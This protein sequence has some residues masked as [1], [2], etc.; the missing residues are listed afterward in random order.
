VTAAFVDLAVTEIKVQELGQGALIQ[1]TVKNLGTATADANLYKLRVMLDGNPLQGG[2]QP[3]FNARTPI[4]PNQTRVTGIIPTQS[5]QIE[6]T[7]RL[8]P[9][10]AAAGDNPANNILTRT[11]NLP[12][13]RPDFTVTDLSLMPDNR[14][15]VTIR[16]SGGYA[17]RDAVVSLEVYAGNEPVGVG[18]PW[19]TLWPNPRETIV[20][21]TIDPIVGTRNVRATVNPNRTTLEYNYENNTLAK[22]LTAHIF[23]PD[24]I[25]WKLGL[26]V[27]YPG[28]VHKLAVIIA[29]I[30]KATS[31]RT[32]KAEVFFGD[33]LLA[34][35]TLEG[36][37]A[38]RSEKRF[39]T[40]IRI[41]YGSTYRVTVD[42]QNEV[43]EERKNN[44]SL[45]ATAEL[46]R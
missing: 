10:G 30:G 43:D 1:V 26:W 19:G 13:V 46:L 28:P 45:T 36:P 38:S 2:D 31:P 12:E 4:E 25:V 41:D 17:P 9:S 39:D 37:I 23:K 32:I 16:N 7:A 15:Q 21:T 35:T 44:N 6:V 42:P 40:D 34:T 18:L 24:L 22:K 11:L 14:I 27:D 5:G 8:I 3:L 20:V 33:Q 29:N